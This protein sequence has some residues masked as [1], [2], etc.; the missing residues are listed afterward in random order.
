MIEQ[1]RKFQVEIFET[2]NILMGSNCN[3]SPKEKRKQIEKFMYR[4]LILLL[5]DSFL[6]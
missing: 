1:V 6:K 3:I 2:K 5:C 4:S